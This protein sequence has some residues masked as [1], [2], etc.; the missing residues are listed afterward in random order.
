M[1]N[2]AL[3]DYP[4]MYAVKFRSLLATAGIVGAVLVSA[5]GDD[6]APQTP[7]PLPSTGT[8]TLK[9]SAP[10]IVAP[11]GGA[12]INTR[13]PTL[14]L[15]PSLGTY[16]QQNV[17][18]EVQVLTTTGETVYSRT[19]AGGPANGQGT[20]SHVV[21][22]PLNVRT[23]YRWRARAVS[24]SVAGPW[25]DSSASGAT[26]FVT[27]TLTPGSSNADF[28]DYFF[29]LTAQK[30]LTFPSQEAFVAMDADLV[31][32]GIIIAKDSSGF[33][34]GRIYLPTSGADKVGL[35]REHLQIEHQLDVLFEVARDAGRRGRN[36]KIVRERL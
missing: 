6:P 34:R 9:V 18:Y 12:A 25:S 7:T 24:G 29:S 30:N 16:T 15:Q 13:T 14:I 28:R 2:R 36:G 3:Q 31:G 20:L 10:T 17:S 27:N 8:T 35:P 4:R 22:T 11:S 26:M 32:V 23:S 21:D 33:I 19:I 5:C 1:F